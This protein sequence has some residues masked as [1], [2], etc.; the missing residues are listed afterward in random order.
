MSKKIKP[1]LPQ[2]I[3]RLDYWTIAVRRKGG[4]KG[5]RGN[6][7]VYLTVT[8]YYRPTYVAWIL[9]FSRTLAHI[10]TSCAIHVS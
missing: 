10:R 8:L 6:D 4:D 1:D 7:K 9:K 5:V 2:N 3:W